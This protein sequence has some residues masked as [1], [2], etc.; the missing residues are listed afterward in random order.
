MTCPQCLGLE[1][2]FDEGRVRSKVREYQQG[3]LPR[4]SRLLREALMEGGVA[5]RTVLDIGGG[6]GALA[7]ELLA[8]GAAHATLV[9]ASS[10]SVR[11]AQAEAERRGLD[12]RL[13]ILHGDFV[14][15]APTLDAHDIVLLDRVVCCYHDVDALVGRSAAHARERLGLVYPR[16]RWWIRLLPHALAAGQRLRRRPYRLYIH[17]PARVQQQAR[18]AGLT[19]RPSRRLFFWRLDLFDRA[20]PAP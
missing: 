19:D 11:A 4:S 8:A 7:M 17:P 5:G 10:A 6:I 9:E 16:Y 18:A 2:E 3:K 1:Q 12:D 20:P 14:T 13:Q 15:L